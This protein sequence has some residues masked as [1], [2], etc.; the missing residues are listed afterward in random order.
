MFQLLH[1]IVKDTETLEESDIREGRTRMTNHENGLKKRESGK[2]KWSTL[3]TPIYFARLITE[4]LL[5]DSSE[6]GG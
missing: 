5:G 1:G 2:K 4:G 3:T 6:V